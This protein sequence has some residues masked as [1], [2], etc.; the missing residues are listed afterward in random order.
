MTSILEKRAGNETY[1][2]L[3]SQNFLESLLTRIPF[4]FKAGFRPA[5]GIMSG[6][7][8][9]KTCKTRQFLVQSIYEGTRSLY[10]QTH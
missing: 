6:C 4:S 10:K 3:I 9:V 8:K 1:Y 2:G 5:K 7:Q